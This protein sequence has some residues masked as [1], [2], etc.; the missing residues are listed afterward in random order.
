ML[1]AVPEQFDFVEFG[2]IGGQKLQAQSAGGL[3]GLMGLHAGGAVDAGVVEHEHRGP[4]QVLAA[5]VE[6]GSEQVG[7]ERALST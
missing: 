2:A 4:G 3:S 7:G 6:D 1:A 5:L